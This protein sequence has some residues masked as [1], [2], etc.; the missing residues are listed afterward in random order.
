MPFTWGRIDVAVRRRVAPRRVSVGDLAEGIVEVSNPEG[1]RVSAM[2]C[3]DRV[4]DGWAEVS[5]PR[6]GPGD[7]VSLPYRLPTGRR[8][9]VPVGPLEVVRGD[10]FGLAERTNRLGTVVELYVHP[11]IHRIAAPEVGH[12]VDLDA[13]AVGEVRGDAAFHALREYQ[14]GD[15]L[16]RVH[17]KST[18]H[19][20]Q[21]MIRE[22]VD[23]VRPDTTVV[24][25]QRAE[26]HVDDRFELAVEVAAS[27]VVA[28]IDAGFPVHLVGTGER[29]VGGVVS[30]RRESVLDRLALVEPHPGD[31]QPLDR[32]LFRL[33]RGGRMLVVVTGA[34]VPHDV[35]AVVAAGRRFAEVVVVS[36]APPGQGGAVPSPL[37][38][39]RA[40]T[41]EDF[42]A[43]WGRR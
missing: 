37:R 36:T 3:R 8:G 13:E 34:L 9:V 26:R 20:G 12:Q 38:L 7:G 39:V 15:D 25:D 24:L 31:D 2:V 30:S 41:P 10:P 5:V 29:L 28:S 40:T 27:V 35:A 33:P 23:P 43:A 6:L 11:R 17:W 18:A 16:R 19:R 4:G 21:L 22:H 32:V 1:T 14:V 42:V